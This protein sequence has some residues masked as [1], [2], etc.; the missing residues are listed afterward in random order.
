LVISSIDLG[1]NRQ[2]TASLGIA[3]SHV[4][5]ALVSLRQRADAAAYKAKN[6]GRNRVCVAD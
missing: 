6:T 4:G 2:L 1:E 3:L 5:E